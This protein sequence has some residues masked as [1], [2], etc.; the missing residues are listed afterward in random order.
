MT[1]E[2][3]AFDC[4]AICANHVLEE[5]VAARREGREAQRA[6]VPRQNLAHARG[7]S[8]IHVVALCVACAALPRDWPFCLRN[9][10]SE[11]RC[12]EH[13]LLLDASSSK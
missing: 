3:E 5:C 8:E 9:L 4:E 11:S 7:E 1:K 12:K 10:W 13:N 6:F 2:R